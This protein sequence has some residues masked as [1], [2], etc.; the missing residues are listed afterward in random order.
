MSAVR[1]AKNAGHTNMKKWMRRNG[2][3]TPGVFMIL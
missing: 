2:W 1:I 3:I